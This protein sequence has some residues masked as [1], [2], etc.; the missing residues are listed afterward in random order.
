MYNKKYISTAET[1]SVS[2]GKCILHSIVIGETAAGAI[3]IKDGDTTIGVLKASIAE[4]VYD[5]D[6]VINESLS[7]VT[8]AASKIV[9]TWKPT[10]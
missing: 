2:T 4:G 10:A 6:M 9:V 7:V 1:T 3:T 8:A 5:F